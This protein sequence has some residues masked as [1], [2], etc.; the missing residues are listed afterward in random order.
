MATWRAVFPILLRRLVS[1]GP[2]GVRRSLNAARLAG[3]GLAVGG[4]AVCGALLGTGWEFGRSERLVVRAQKEDANDEAK[5]SQSIRKQ[6]FMQFASLE[7]E[8]EHYMTPRDF[9]FS[10]MFEQMERKTIARSLKKQDV[11][12]VLT[13]A[14]KVKPGPHFFRDLG[15]KGMISYTEYLFLLT[16]LTKPQTGF[17][18]A[19]KMLDTDGNEQVEKR[20]FFKLQRI[21]GHKAEL[22]TGLGNIPSPEDPSSESSDV[23]T[24]LLVH[25]FGRG[26]RE[27]LQFS[28]FYKFM[29]NLQTEVQEMEFIQFSKGM[30]FMRKEDF[31]EWLLFFTDEENNDIYWQNVQSRI[32]PGESISIEEFKSFYQFMNNLEDF[33][34]TMKMFSV[35]NRAVKLAEFKRAVKVATGQEL[36]NNVLETIFKIFDRDGDN[37]LSHGEFLGVLKNR[38][39]RGLKHVP[40]QQGFEGYWKCVKRETIKGANEAWKQTGK[41]PF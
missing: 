33:S 23:N 27:K 15:D 28:E 12:A 39:H 2:P 21:L 25:F 41:S 37:C 24:T 20:E 30:N 40:Q 22:K 5:E 7:Y 10:V 1:S 31:A 11:D 3:A 4:S 35:A 32:P 16:I 17:H 34:I 38:L 19:F 13:Q 8:G 36:S 26:G 18:M 29:D 14:T 6:R 9:L